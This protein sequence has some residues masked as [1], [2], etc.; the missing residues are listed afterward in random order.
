M[1]NNMANEKHPTD[2]ETALKGTV[3]TI[4]KKKKYTNL[5]ASF[6]VPVSKYLPVIEGSQS[7]KPR[8]S[9][10]IAYRAIAVAVEAVKGEGMEHDEVIVKEWGVSS[11]FSLEELQFINTP[12]V[13]DQD[14]VKFA[15]RYA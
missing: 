9:E 11:Y 13:T 1:G 14:R 2:P 15:W 10:K 7:I 12:N 8:S 3:R 4:T 6:N 5:V